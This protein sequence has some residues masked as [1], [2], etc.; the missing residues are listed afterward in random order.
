MEGGQ[1]GHRHQLGQQGVAQVS[2]PGHQGVQEGAARH[3]RNK[4]LLSDLPSREGEF[5]QVEC[6]QV[7][8]MTFTHTWEVL[9]GDV[10]EDRGE[11]FIMNQE[12][13][14]MVIEELGNTSSRAPRIIDVDAY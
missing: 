7:L 5:P 10:L 8:L 2:L 11:V 14:G 13:A 4:A 9:G 12:D 6:W 1:G 3:G